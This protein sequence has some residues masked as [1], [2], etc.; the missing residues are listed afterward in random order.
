MK[1]K[2]SLSL[3]VVLAVVLVITSFLAIITPDLLG[4]KG[5]I[6]LSAV[7]IILALFAA[8]TIFITSRELEKLS[9]DVEQLASGK[10]TVRLKTKGINGEIGKSI[11][12]L[13]GNTKKLVSETLQISQKNK[14]TSEILQKSM[15][16]TAHSLQDIDHSIL[17][18]ANDTTMQ[19]ETAIET[20]GNTNEMNRNAELISNFAD[21]N[22]QT[23]KETLSVIN[24]NDIILENLIKKLKST[25]EV[26]KNLAGSVHTLSNEMDKIN[27]ITTSV[28]EISDRT[29]LLALNAAIEAARAG[30][31]G[32]GFAVVADEVRKLAEQ[33]SRSAGEIKKLIESTLVSISNIINETEEEVKIIVENIA[34]ADQTKAAFKKIVESTNSNF[35]SINEIGGISNKTAEIAGR[36]SNLMD[37][38]SNATQEAVGF[39]EE[40]SA[41]S[42]QQLEAIAAT[43]ELINN[44]AEG[45]NHLDVKLNDFLCNI[46]VGEKELSMIS[47]GFVVLRE[48]AEE[49]NHKGIQ[50]NKASDFLREKAKNNPQFEYFAIFNEKGITSSESDLSEEDTWDCSHRPYFKEAIAG[51]Q[52]TTEPY[53]SSVSFNYC[54]T[55][56]MPLP[57]KSGVIMG[58]ICIEG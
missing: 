22:K 57:N 32:K 4:S 34:Y 31:Q 10:L 49:L 37:K 25:A 42:N 27:N 36:V 38:I 28:T 23:V 40:V 48:M 21:K 14:T 29:N 41:S 44:L 35:D 16:Q 3:T 51:K 2:T 39:T 54:I 9:D 56:S 47:K 11:N 17:E 6:I 13:V 43:A 5:I 30:E 15:L 50:I 19:A 12:I 20:K 8:I 7:G 46:T 24:E 58:D 53:I 1:L 45:A 52:Y 26:S 18:I 33:S 55:I